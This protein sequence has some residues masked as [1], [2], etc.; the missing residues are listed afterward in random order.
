MTKE[1]LEEKFEDCF[2]ASTRPSEG[3][4]GPDVTDESKLWKL[5]DPIIA[6]YAKQQ[7]IA[8]VAWS[9]KNNHYVGVNGEWYSKD[10][11]GVAATTGAL[12]DQFIEQQNKQQTNN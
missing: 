11:E 4:Y 8:L 9:I 5:F 6:S 3:G 2:T 10:G 1:D 7:A 12:Y